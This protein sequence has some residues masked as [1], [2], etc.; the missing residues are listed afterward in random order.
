MEHE[1]QERLLRY[2]RKL[3]FYSSTEGKRRTSNMPL[4]N[5]I[6]TQMLTNSKCRACCFQM[7]KRMMLSPV[8]NLVMNILMGFIINVNIMIAI[9]ILEG[10]VRYD[11][12]PNTTLQV[13]SDRLSYTTIFVPLIALGVIL[14]L[15]TIMT[16]I[17]LLFD[18][19]EK[20]CLSWQRDS[21]GLLLQKLFFC[22]CLM[23]TFVYLHQYVETV[24]F[25]N[26]SDIGKHSSS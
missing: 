7:K 10:K 24:E 3:S 15:I 26:Y 17:V 1:Q 11:N 23:L 16:I 20:G 13:M 18:L 25:G 22:M 6:A 19:V 12:Q 2:E 14:T 5:L 8:Q 21:L 9:V 4:K